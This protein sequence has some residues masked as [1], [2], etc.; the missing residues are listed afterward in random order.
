MRKP[1]ALDEAQIRTLH[2]QG[3]TDNEIAEQLGK[4]RKTVVGP[5]N[6]SQLHFLTCTSAMITLER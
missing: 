1:S 4:P 3:L 6:P 2:A 5:E